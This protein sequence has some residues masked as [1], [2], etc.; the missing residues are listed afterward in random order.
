MILA[1]DVAVA[2]SALEPEREPVVEELAGARAL[3][4]FL[5]ILL[6]VLDERFVRDAVAPLVGP[7]RIEEALYDAPTI[8]EPLE[9][10]FSP[11][12]VDR[13][14][15]ELALGRRARCR[16]ARQIRER[17]QELLRDVAVRGLEIVDG[18]VEGPREDPLRTAETRRVV[19]VGD[20]RIGIVLHHL[21]ESAADGLHA[22]RDLARG[23]GR[24]DRAR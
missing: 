9:H 22:R 16:R 8:L 12:S 10:R 11:E 20:P 19:R 1:Q 7:A 23:I 3:R 24:A 15:D 18:L 2:P 5:T 14:G 17:P 13:V 21:P 4:S 6:D